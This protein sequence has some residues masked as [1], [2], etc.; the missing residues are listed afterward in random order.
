MG[1][2]MVGA[3]MIGLRVCA[4]GK[5]I[6][7]SLLGCRVPWRMIFPLWKM[8]SLCFSKRAV[9]PASHTYPI[10]NREPEAKCGKM[11]VFLALG[12]NCEMANTVVCVAFIA[13]L[14]D[15]RALLPLLVAVIF[16]RGRSTCTC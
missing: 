6:V 1:S 12:G 4:G 13:V 11:C 7:D 8:S 16:V 14:L 5:S 15:R 2:A 9:Q 10:D 3:S